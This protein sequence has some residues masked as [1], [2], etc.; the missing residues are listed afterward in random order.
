MKCTST[1]TSLKTG[2]STW[3]YWRWASG[4][5]FLTKD[6]MSLREPS[7][8]MSMSPGVRIPA[9]GYISA[10]P[11]PFRMQL[12]KPSDCN[13]SVSFTAASFVRAFRFRICSLSASHRIISWRGGLAPASPARHT[14]RN[15]TPTSDC[16]KANSCRPSQSISSHAPAGHGS[17]WKQKR[18]K[19][20]YWDVLF[21]LSVLPVE[22]FHRGLSFLGDAVSFQHLHHRNPYHLQVSPEGTMIHIPHV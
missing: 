16:F 10:L 21:T 12:R 19:G 1:G 20:R 6:S 5:Y 22:G 18:K 7:T 13:R 8:Q 14:P 11:C 3:W 4:M 9:S 15:I 17:S 2:K